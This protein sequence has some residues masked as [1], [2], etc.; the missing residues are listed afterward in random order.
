MLAKQDIYPV[1]LVPQ[2]ES[3][4]DVFAELVGDSPTQAKE[5]VA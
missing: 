5:H 4:R 2:R 1:E 3:L